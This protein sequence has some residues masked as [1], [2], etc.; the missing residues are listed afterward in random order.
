MVYD[1]GFKEM[2]Q[3]SWRPVSE[4]EFPEPVDLAPAPVGLEVQPAAKTGVYRPPG[5]RAAT[6]FTM[7]AF[8][9]LTIDRIE[10]SWISSLAQLLPERSAQEFRGQTLLNSRLQLRHHLL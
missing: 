1:L 5:A 4:S 10:L 6:S 2:Y 8:C 7:V 3:I 9:Y